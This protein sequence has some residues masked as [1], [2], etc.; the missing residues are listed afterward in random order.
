MWGSNSEW[1]NV[2]KLSIKW[3]NFYNSH[4]KGYLSQS[5]KIWQV[6]CKTKIA[7]KGLGNGNQGIGLQVRTAKI[8]CDRF[9]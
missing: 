2:Q 6:F 5:T 7:S 4:T 3:H 8:M 9:A 1:I